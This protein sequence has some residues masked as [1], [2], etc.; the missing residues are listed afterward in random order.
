MNG[1]LVIWDQYLLESMKWDL[2]NL[3]SISFNKSPD[4]QCLELLQ[5]AGAT[6]VE[7]HFVG[8]SMAVGVNDR[9]EQNGKHTW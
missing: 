8:G 4:G 3:G 1:I 6:K 9:V 5:R 7:K 2:S